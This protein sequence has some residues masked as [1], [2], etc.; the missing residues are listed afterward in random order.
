MPRPSLAFALSLTA[1]AILVACGG[2]GG[3][4]SSTHESLASVTVQTYITDNLA[5][6]YSKVWVTLKKIT[7]VDAAGS[8]V[9]LVDASASPVVLNLSSLASVGE[10]MSSVTIP[11]GVYT[12]LNVTLGDAVQLVSL[13][14][15]QTTAASFSGT[16]SDFVLQVR[17]LQVDA[18]SSG[19][20]VL[21]FNL[22]RFS[23]DA[24]TGLV[25]PVVEVPRPA[26][27]FGK[28][29][30]QQAE[31]HG[32]VRSVDVAN[33]TLT[34]DDARLGSGIVVT[35]AA[36]AVILDAS[37]ATLTLDAL[38]ALSQA[39][40]EIKGTVT[41]GATTADPVAVQASV[42]HVLPATGSAAAAEQRTQGSG[43]VSAVNGQR[44]T[45]Q[46]AEANFL[47]GGGSVVVDITDAVFPHGQASDLAAGVPVSF[48]GTASGSGDAA[49]VVARMVDIRGAASAAERGQ[50]PGTQYAGLHGVV[51][52][53]GSSGT[54]TLVVGASD[55]R[56]AAGTYTVDASTA[57]YAEGNAGCL[58]ADASVDAMGTLSGQAL[59][60][61]VIAVKG[62]AG[63][64]RSAPAP[65][66]SA[67][68]ASAPQ[69]SAPAA[70]AP[71]APA[72][73]ASVP[74][75]PAPGASA[76]R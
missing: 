28:F 12:Q 31:V 18:T 35:L 13:D 62:C 7:A 47:P 10:F 68:G 25:T 46:L 48:R 5:T 71:P 16:G 67:G 23:Y 49:V 73:A 56:V 34:V 38:A 53:V 59:L 76:P 63:Q 75:P 3:S 50:N 21:D 37:G 27:A 20:L 42:I 33:A 6:D 61:K 11:A 32:L 40:I 70:S 74:V 54:F 41:P 36:D 22:A 60:A 72:P 8:E 1:L 24:A 44:V 64:P 55:G 39:R 51:S 69:P 4:S 30:R 26:D 14:G 9:V 52:S 58:A 45:V 43:T 15:S 17:H 65:V 66:P 29:V 57:S 2:G 19:Q